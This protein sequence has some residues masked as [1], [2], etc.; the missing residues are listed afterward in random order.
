MDL[1]VITDLKRYSYWAFDR[2]WPSIDQL[3]DGQFILDL[4]NSV[5][6]IRN[7]IIH[8]ISGHRRWIQRLKGTEPSTHLV[9]ENYPTKVLVNNEWVTFKDEMFAYIS[10]LTNQTLLESVRYR[11]PSRSVESQNTRWEI[12]VHLVNHSTDHR[13]QIL[14]MLRNNFDIIT[15]EH[16]YIFY[17]WSKEKNQS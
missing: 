16:D 4:H 14:S 11:I 8:L 10:T 5:G 15:P 1:H 13:A 17:L 6:S 9:Y 12:L 2:I 7:Q 3:K